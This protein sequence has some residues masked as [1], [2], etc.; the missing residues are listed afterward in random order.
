M[1][2]DIQ[3]PNLETRLA[4]LR[5]KCG[6]RR[7]NFQDDVLEYI[8]QN[9][10]SNIRELEGALNRIA[11]FCQLNNSLPT[12]DTTKQVLES[13]LGT[14]RGQN[15]SAEKI[16]K[17]VADFFNLRCED[18]LSACRQRELVYPRQITMYLMRQEM[19][20]SYPRIGKEL[21]GKDHTTIIH[22]VG[23]INKEI[24]KNENLQKDLLQ[25]KEKLYLV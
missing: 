22:G 11:A 4:I 20:F 23:K 8:A 19:N 7:C 1:V 18:L 16:L 25:I 3:P 10:Q 2:A 14:R 12:L 21:G 6:E 17:T 15:L 13:V 5:A 9:I 24:G